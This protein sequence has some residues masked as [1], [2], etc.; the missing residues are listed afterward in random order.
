MARK[1]KGNNVISVD[2]TNAGGSALFPEGSGY[3]FKVLSAEHKDVGENGRVNIKCECLEAESKKLVGKTATNSFGLGDSSLWVFRNFLMALGYEIPEGPEDVDLDSLVGMEFVCDNV[4]NT[5]NDRTNNQFGNFLPAEGEVETSDDEDEEEVVVKKKKSRDEDEE[6]EEDEAP[7][8][9]RKKSRDAD[10]EDDEE[11]EAPKK[12]R[13]SRD[14]EDEDEDETPKKKKKS[15]VEDDD[16]ED[17]ISEDEVRSMDVKELKG[18]IKK[19]GLD[20]DLSDFATLRKQAMAVA[21]A[22]EEEG[23]LATED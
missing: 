19:H 7:K 5:Y 1:K 15:K 23:L 10:E 17:K 20:V 2:F 3:R 9:K 14:E 11:E 12:K 6:D 21:A 8:S 4:H 22:L 18:L 13:K 16:D